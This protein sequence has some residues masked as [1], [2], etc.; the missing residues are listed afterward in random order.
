MGSHFQ[1][2]PFPTKIIQHSMEQTPHKLP[3]LGVPPTLLLDD[4]LQGSDASELE[5][6]SQQSSSHG[7]YKQEGHRRK[8]GRVYCTVV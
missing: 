6:H 7:I 5:D 3:A 1:P 2:C 4:S 8:A